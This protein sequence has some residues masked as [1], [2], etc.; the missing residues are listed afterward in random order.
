V[1]YLDAFQPPLFFVDGTLPVQAVLKNHT[2][3]VFR[4]PNS[5][6]TES[7]IQ[8]FHTGSMPHRELVRMAP[9]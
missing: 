5:D 7:G 2:V 4:G 6:I 1:H 9:Q 3:L 8:V